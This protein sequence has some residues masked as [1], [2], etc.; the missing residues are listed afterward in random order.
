[1]AAWDSSHPHGL[2]RAIREDVE[3]V[4]WE[5]LDLPAPGI[6]GKRGRPF[7]GG[8]SYNEAA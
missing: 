5:A 4:V 8:E 7:I 2:E 3:V 6:C 1:V